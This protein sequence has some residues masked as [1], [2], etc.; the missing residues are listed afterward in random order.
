MFFITSSTQSHFP[1]YNPNISTLSHRVRKYLLFDLIPNPPGL[2]ISLR[3]T[4]MSVWHIKLQKTWNKRTHTKKH[5]SWWSHTQFLFS[6]PPLPFLS[7]IFILRSTW[8]IRVRFPNNFC[9]VLGARVHFSRISFSI[10]LVA[11]KFSI[12]RFCN[13]MCISTFRGCIVCIIGSQRLSCFG[14]LLNL[15]SASVLLSNHLIFVFSA[16]LRT[17]LSFSKCQCLLKR[18]LYNVYH[19]RILLWVLVLCNTL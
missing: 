15:L 9:G 7:H 14:F 17:P 5:V 19:F 11:N 2:G 12:P 3:N 16:T 13:N 18:Q 10:S 1:F 4:H 6:T 8:S